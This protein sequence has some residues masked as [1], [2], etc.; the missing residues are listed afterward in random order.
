MM[1]KNANELRHDIEDPRSRL[2]ETFDAI[3]SK[4]DRTMEVLADRVDAAKSVVSDKVGVVKSA[5]ADTTARIADSIPTADDL[6]AGAGWVGKMIKE[7]PFGMAIGSVAVGFL[8]GLLLPRTSMETDRIN[9]VKQMAKD[10][11]AQAV[12]AGKLV[13]LETIFGKM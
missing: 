6:R 13:V 9:D 3:G 10:A 8:V 7:N 12:E 4:A 1:D 5:V 2:G 11:G